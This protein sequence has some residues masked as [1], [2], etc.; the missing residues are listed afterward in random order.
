MTDMDMVTGMAV[1][2]GSTLHT[3]CKPCIKGKQTRAEICKITETRVDTVLSC[4]FTDVCSPLH[5][6]YNGYRYFV[7][8]VDD[9]SR[10]VHINGLKAKSEVTDCL[11]RFVTCAEVETR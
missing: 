8:W 4:I 5:P 2:K 9:K 3:P 11:K 1:M 7:T 6:N 10:K